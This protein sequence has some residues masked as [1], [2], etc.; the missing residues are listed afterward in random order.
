MKQAPG[1]NCPVYGG[2]RRTVLQVA[3]SGRGRHY[4][5]QR[6]AINRVGPAISKYLERL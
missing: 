6:L 5:K 3:D 4:E 2:V 1:L